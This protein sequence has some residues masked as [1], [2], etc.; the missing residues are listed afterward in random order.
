MSRSSLQ[1]LHRQRIMSDRRF[2]GYFV[3]GAQHSH[4]RKVQV[5][6]G[7]LP[8]DCPSDKTT[9]VVEAE[10]RPLLPVGA[11]PCSCS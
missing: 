5:L 1:H 4:R 11:D 6:P 10:R 3:S 2:R 8:A 9:T 7:L